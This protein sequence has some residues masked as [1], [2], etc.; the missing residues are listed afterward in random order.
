[1][2]GKW[3]L[4]DVAY[5]SAAG[6]HS[7]FYMPPE[8]IIRSYLPLEAYWQLLAQPLSHDQ[9][10][11]QP[12]ISPAL[13]CSGLQLCTPSLRAVHRLAAC[14]CAPVPTL[15]K[16]CTALSGSGQHLASTWHPP[17]ERGLL[18]SPEQ[19]LA[20]GMA[21]QVVAPPSLQRNKRPIP[22]LCSVLPC[23]H[24]VEKEHLASPV[25]ETSHH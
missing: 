12:A 14:W 20:V 13:F 10:W 7:A 21:E 8:A 11:E 9:F 19:L 3:Q 25:P 4:L 1:M 5:A 6:G 22:A 24:P 23:L 15:C 2:D 16:P 18:E 17:G